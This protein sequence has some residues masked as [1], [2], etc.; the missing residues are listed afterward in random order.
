MLAYGILFAG[1][2]MSSL[3]IAQLGLSVFLFILGSFILIASYLLNNAALTTRIDTIVDEVEEN[4]LREETEGEDTPTAVAAVTLKEVLIT[5][6]KRCQY[7]HHMLSVFWSRVPTR[8][9]VEHRLIAARSCVVED[10]R[11]MMDAAQL[12]ESNGTVSTEVNT[13]SKKLN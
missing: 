11:E 9:T 6:W 5:S 10:G 1:C 2:F 13:G 7:V 12:A 8:F 3:V 4:I